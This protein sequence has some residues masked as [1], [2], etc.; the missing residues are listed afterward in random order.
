VV[1]DE[2]TR[3]VIRRAIIGVLLLAAGGLL[4]WSAS[5][6]AKPTSPSL[7]DPAVEALT[8]E[9]ETPNVLRQST[10]GIDLKPGWDADLVVTVNGR[11]VDIPQDEERNVEAQ[12]Q[13]FFTPGEGKAIEDLG[14]GLVQVTAIIWRP[15]DGQTRE[16]GSRSVRWSFHVS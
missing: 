16:Q 9:N 12:N 2:A 6:K 8:P 11:S 3:T 10:I 4:W 5:F 14:P 7:T 15:I 13:V 1:V